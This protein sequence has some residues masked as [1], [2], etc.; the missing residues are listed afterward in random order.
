MFL[1]ELKP[2]LLLYIMKEIPQVLQTIQLELS[3]DAVDI[4]I[5][6]WIRKVKIR[7]EKIFEMCTTS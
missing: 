1:Q 4:I 7:R 5:R 2:L 6:R 3:N